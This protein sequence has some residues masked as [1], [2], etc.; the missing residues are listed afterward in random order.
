M[1]VVLRF[2]L[3]MLVVSGTSYAQDKVRDENTETLSA[4]VRVKS[5]ILPNARSAESLGTAR[6]GNGVLIRENLVLTIGYLVIE[7]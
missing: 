6:E 3:M 7:A 1:G 5:R 4:V 2:V